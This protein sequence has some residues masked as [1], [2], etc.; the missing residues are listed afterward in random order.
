LVE[1]TFAFPE[2]S[3][4]FL[5]LK[6]FVMVKTMLALLILPLLC[7][8]Q[9]DK[10][11]ISAMDDYM[12]GQSTFYDFS[13]NVLVAKKGK[14]L[15]EK[16]FGFANR[17]WSTPNSLQS[18]FRIGSITKQ[19]TAAA[20]MQL[21]DQGKLNLDDKLTRFFPDFPGGE[22]VT[23]H[24][25]LNHSS[26]ISDYTGL[27]N[28]RSLERLSYPRDSVIA[29]F[30]NRP[31]NFAS[32]TQWSYSNSGYFLLGLI[33]EK[34]SGQSYHA[35]LQ[36]N[37]FAKAGMTNSLVDRT[38]TI[39]PNRAL[40]Y[41]RIPGGFKNAGFTS[42]EF[43][44]SAGAILSTVEDMYKWNQALFG[45]KILSKEMFTKMTT[46]YLNHY[47]YGIYIDT[48]Q[49]KK[50]IRH[51]GGISGYL[52]HGVYFP[53][54]DLYIIVLSNN[55]S[56]SRGIANALS[57]IAFGKPIVP[58]YKHKVAP[59]DPN[60]L[61]KYVGKYTTTDLTANNTVELIKKDGK[62]YRK[63]PVNIFELFPESN[64]KFFYSDQTDTQ[65]NFILDASGKVVRAEFIRNGFISDL[66]KVQ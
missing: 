6:H 63:T 35:Y 15:Y 27:P 45:G 55:V 19:F 12:K 59:I 64:T 37:L 61:D 43:P 52:N 44:F 66:K 28:F 56:E 31:Y 14:V 57:A 30:K 17:E 3:E 39:I 48:L 36:E 54:D 50:L 24:M 33:V 11:I 18:R 42:M 5:Q 65:I 23:I 53:D 32:G 16:A 10:N 47:G 51:S 4:L 8:A 22:N 41:Q 25:L 38:D 58:A 60:E 2:R 29:L 13:G 20:I 49:N 40:G 62:L 7:V 34:A 26:G 21:A 1:T 46:P 9:N